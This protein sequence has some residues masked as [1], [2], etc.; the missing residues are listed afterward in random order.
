MTN[1]SEEDKLEL[2]D[3][4]MCKIQR[5]NYLT[6]FI[7]FIE[8]YN[9]PTEEDDDYIYE[10]PFHYSDIKNLTIL[11]EF[12]T[13]VDHIIRY[14][15]LDD[16][17]DVLADDYLNNY[18]YYDFNECPKKIFSHIFINDFKMYIYQ[19]LNLGHTLK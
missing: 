16:S 11:E 4:I 3:E 7:D 15:A 9:I 19:N 6:D 18:I 12:H 13:I 17:F 10:H 1:I 8:L 2:F 14:D 5:E